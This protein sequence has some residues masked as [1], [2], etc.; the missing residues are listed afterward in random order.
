VISF[1]PL[2]PARAVIHGIV[3]IPVLLFPLVAIAGVGEDLASAAKSPYEIARFVDTHITFRWE[4]LWKSLGIQNDVF[5]QPCG[6][7]NG[8]KRDCSE[9]FIT[10]PDPFQVILILRHGL[11]MPEV[12]LR[13]LRE[14]GTGTT[15]PWKF[16]GYYS[17]L[18]KY[19]EPRHRML[20]FGMKPFLVVTRQG[21]SGSG[22][23]SEIDDWIDLTTEKF[24]P[25]FSL[26]TKGHYSGE[27]DD[28]GLDTAALVVSTEPS[29]VEW[30]QV[31]YTARF[32]HSGKAF[33]SFRSDNAVY[34]RRGEGFV[35]DAT[36]SK[37][38]RADIDNL[39]DIN[40]DQ[41]SREDYLRY[42][43]PDLKKI[44]AGR[45]GDLK[46]WLTRFL[47][48]CENTREERELELLL[49]RGP[50]KQ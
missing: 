47:A 21:I 8:A 23:S 28:V 38:P 9:E 26:T 37:T 33:R 10:I 48:T 34:V 22:W 45:A 20:R 46:D 1:R 12:Y 19:F 15:A 6:E 7:L 29:P 35:F 44:A 11:A 2:P 39:Y 27:P 32:S 31:A 40:F 13:F 17:P 24:E 43:L 5:M 16:G 36:R 25:V 49:H 42:L 41:P 18:V 3:A 30:I 50:T 14:R 4:P